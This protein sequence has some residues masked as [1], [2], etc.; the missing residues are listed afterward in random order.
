MTTSVT[1]ET[2]PETEMYATHKPNHKT[3][4]VWELLVFPDCFSVVLV[5]KCYPFMCF[6]E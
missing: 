5:D 3:F 4:L 2:V 1:L 6:K